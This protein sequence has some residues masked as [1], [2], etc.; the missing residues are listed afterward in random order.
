MIKVKF[1]FY[2]SIHFY[3][4]TNKR[5]GAVGRRYQ[6]IGVSPRSVSLICGGRDKIHSIFQKINFKKWTNLNKLRR[7]IILEYFGYSWN[8]HLS[9]N[10]H[11][12]KT[13]TMIA[14]IDQHYHFIGDE[15]RFAENLILALRENVQRFQYNYY[16][17][18]KDIL[19]LEYLI[20]K[21]YGIKTDF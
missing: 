13:E 14:N 3:F 12:I 19:F 6:K 21:T 7:T 16:G 18:E 10:I 20:K 11:L 15:R 5:I 4:K 1:V 8:G 17:I 2:K 9:P